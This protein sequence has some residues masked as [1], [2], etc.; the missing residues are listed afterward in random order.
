M[1]SVAQFTTYM[2][3]EK[4]KGTKLA[5]YTFHR[6]PASYNLQGIRLGG[7]IIKNKLFFFVSY[8]KRE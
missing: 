2:Q 1:S 6:T 8:E 4:Y 3:N 7:P 5:K